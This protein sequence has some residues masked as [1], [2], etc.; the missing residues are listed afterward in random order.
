MQRVIDSGWYLRGREVAA[1]EEEWAA[2]CGQAFCVSC[3]SGTDALTLASMG[4][5]MTR[6]RIQA[7]T[8][9]LTAVGLSRGG[10]QIELCEIGDDGRPLTVDQA[11]VPVLLY[12]RPPSAG[13]ENAS[14]FDAAHAHGWQPPSQATACWSFYP[15]KSLGALGDAGAVT[16]NDASLAEEMR[17]LRGQDDRF[18]QKRQITSR[19]DEMQAAVLRVKLKHLD[20]W[21]AE[22]RAIAA[23]YWA[24][25][26]ADI[27]PIS[28]SPKDFHHLFVVQHPRRDALAAHL[29]AEANAE[30]KIH[31]HPA[32]H[33]NAQAW[34]A[35]GA[36][37]PQAEQ[38]CNTVLTLPCYPGLTMDEVDRICEAAARFPS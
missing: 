15:T 1:F 23:R 7:N 13:E 35:E 20:G 27:V 24:Q 2:Y 30:T 36:R 33:A 6:A 32:L 31:F 5:A 12:G 8:L 29:R 28:R 10:A 3:N 14:L 34:A 18:Y 22:R 16:T 17:D 4:L 21:I 19:M 9:P 26:P 25:L 37:F 38:W 11:T